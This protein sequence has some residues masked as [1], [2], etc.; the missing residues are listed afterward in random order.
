M[1]GNPLISTIK[2]VAGTRQSFLLS[3]I[4][5]YLE[6]PLPTDEIYRVIAPDLPRLGLTATKRDGDVE[7]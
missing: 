7:I 2:Y 3:E 5:P 4:V 1:A 6:S